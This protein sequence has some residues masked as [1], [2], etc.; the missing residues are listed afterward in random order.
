L[1]LMAE[2][3]PS[4]V[5]VEITAS[6]QESPPGSFKLHPLPASLELQRAHPQ[7]YAEAALV[8][9][10]DDGPVETAAEAQDGIGD[11]ESGALRAH[12]E[13][14]QHLS[15]DSGQEDADDL[16][17]ARLPDLDWRQLVLQN[18][19]RSIRGLLEYA[20]RKSSSGSTHLTI[21]RP[22]SA[23]NAAQSDE[24]HELTKQDRVQILWAKA[25]WYAT[26]EA[27][28]RRGARIQLR[29]KQ[30]LSSS[31]GK[32]LRRLSFAAPH[33]GNISL[34]ASQHAGVHTQRAAEDQ[35]DE[36]RHLEF[37]AQE[38]GART[39]WNRLSAFLDGIVWSCLTI[40][41]TIWVLGGDDIYILSDPPLWADK[42][43]YSLYVICF[44]QVFFSFSF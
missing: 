29:T 6:V 9:A 22:T 20:R 5:L 25:L 33:R 31:R 23:E 43:V 44:F 19:S 18:P 13:L 27:T 3:A 8:F 36:P 34:A 37:Q 14:E 4:D 16:Q 17:D 10:T 2:D 1:T 15:V 39:N 38:P 42:P 11:V 40:L 12:A 24:E 35:F 30:R 26:Q 32:I 41:S 21:S 28:R 7:S